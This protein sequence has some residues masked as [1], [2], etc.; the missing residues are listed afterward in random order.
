MIENLGKLDT[1]ISHTQAIFILDKWVEWLSV[2][3]LLIPSNL[4]K[5]SYKHM[6]LTTLIGSTK[7]RD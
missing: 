4:K 2:Q 1:G 7:M 3:S 6:V 5:S